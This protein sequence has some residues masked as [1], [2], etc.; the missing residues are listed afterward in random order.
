MTRNAESTAGKLAA[1]A[2][3]LAQPCRLAAAHLGLQVNQAL[4]PAQQVGAQRLLHLPCQWL[5]PGHAGGAAGGGAICGGAA[6]GGTWRRRRRP[7]AD[8]QAGGPHVLR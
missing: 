7:A 6:G 5:R 3:Q 1:P 2:R 4:P 8:G